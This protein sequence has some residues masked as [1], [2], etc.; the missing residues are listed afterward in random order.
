MIIAEQ[1]DAISA[2]Q[3][4]VSSILTKKLKDDKGFV[5]LSIAEADLRPKM[6]AIAQGVPPLAFRIEVEET[7]EDQPFL[8][9]PS[10]KEIPWPQYYF[11]EKPPWGASNFRIY[12]VLRRPGMLE[13]I[14]NATA[15]KI[16]STMRNVDVDQ[17]EVVRFVPLDIFSDYVPAGEE[18]LLNHIRARVIQLLETDHIRAEH[19]SH[20]GRS[21]FSCVRVG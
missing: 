13:A 19:T 21:S 3:A 20:D 10:T 4:E 11:Y 12:V 1:V 5:L 15:E 16:S 9:L 6:E 8:R 2:V 18:I 17:L 7:F 14:I